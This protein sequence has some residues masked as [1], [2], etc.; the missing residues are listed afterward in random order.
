MSQTAARRRAQQAAGSLGGELRHISPEGTS[1]A[2]EK[3]NSV[4]SLVPGDIAKANG[5]EQGTELVLGYDP[6]TK[7][8]LAT[9]RDEV[10]PGHWAEDFV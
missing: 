8:W 7:T 1:K 6:V 2:Q 9:P 4:Y 5:I 3:G 10:G